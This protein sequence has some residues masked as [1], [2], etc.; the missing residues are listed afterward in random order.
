MVTC[1]TH[2][3]QNAILIDALEHTGTAKADNFDRIM[4]EGFLIGGEGNH[5]AL[6]GTAY[7]KGV[8]TA[9]GPSTPMGYARTT[10]AVILARGLEGK[11]GEH[12][13]RVNKDWLVFRRSDHLLPRYVV[14][15]T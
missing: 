9:T 1:V 5:R 14:H 6:N 7:G 2:V 12:S 3:L 13:Q 4:T 15:Y 11:P 8:Y 10:K